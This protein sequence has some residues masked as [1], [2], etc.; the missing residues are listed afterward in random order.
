[1]DFRPVIGLF[2]FTLF[3]VKLIMRQLTSRLPTILLMDIRNNRVNYSTRSNMNNSS[4]H[5]HTI[6]LLRVGVRTG[7]CIAAPKLD[8]VRIF[9]GFLCRLLQQASG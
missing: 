2:T 6:R 9:L 5:K 1:M 3:S 7:L 8:G 4:N